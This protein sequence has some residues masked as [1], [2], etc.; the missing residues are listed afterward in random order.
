[1]S[2]IVVMNNEYK[3]ADALPDVMNYSYRKCTYCGGSGVRFT[4]IESAIKDMMYIK[5]YHN[6]IYGKQV[7]HIVITAD[8]VFDTG[9]AYTEETKA[10][11]ALDLYQFVDFITET[12][13]KVKGYQTC[14]FVHM[15]TLIPHVHIVMNTVHVESGKKMESVSDI[16]YQ[17]HEYLDYKYHEMKWEGVYYRKDQKGY[18]ELCGTVEDRY[19]G[20]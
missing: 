13:Y 16:A 2:N 15:N 12:L 19:C 4:S 9:K 20:Y 17:L 11:D 3:D 14:Y 5:E 1:M 6:K 18:G 7:A 8:T 10:H